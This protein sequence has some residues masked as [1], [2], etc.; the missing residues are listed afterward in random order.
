[1]RYVIA[2]D[3]GTGGVKAS[4]VDEFGKIV[5]DSFI[6]YQTYF[7]GNNWQEQRPDDW[8]NA[9]VESTHKLL[10]SRNELEI[11][12]IVSLAISGHS[13][14]VVPIGKDGELLRDLTPIWSDQRADAEAQEF[15]E[16]VDYQQWYMTTGNGFPAPCYSVFKIM[17]YKNHERDMFERMDKV[18]GTKDYCNYMFTGVLATDPS[19]ASGSGVFNLKNWAYEPTFIQASGL[20][21]DIFPQII[22]S[23]GVV[24]CITPEAAKLT[25]L[26][27][28]VKVICGGVDNSCMALGAKG[29]AD[30]R[31]YT[32]LGSSAWIALVANKPILDFKYKPY[33][34]AHLIEGMY[35]SATCIFSAGS[36]FQWVRNQLCKDLME[37]EK[38]GGE[39]CYE[40]M[41]R[42]AESSPVGANGVLFNPS[43]A[44]G[45]SIEPSPDISGGFV[46]LRLQH[47]REDIIRASM[48][49]VALNL[50]KALDIFRLYYPDIKKMLI[51]GGGA[52]SAV[53]MQIFANVYHT[54]IEKTNIDQQ[55]ATLGAA[56]LALKGVG[57][58]SDYSCMDS[59]HFTE[60]EYVPNEASLQYASQIY[61]RFEK[62]CNLLA[63]L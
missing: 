54:E 40:A 24:G 11:N 60:A 47:T 7:S 51:V 8:W 20:S 23:D 52:K 10:A 14:G 2:Y 59:I 29:N 45:S 44:G 42:L 1:M 36:S 25:G 55:A 32:S 43:L 16:K 58:W 37:A 19:Y 38:S 22:P 56:A 30:G 31:V 39:N 15:F 4:L 35:A 5:Q 12:S 9:V 18:I 27:E 21:P 50:K 46:G 33:V 6:P 57:V 3:L 13:L 53:W 34:F 48:E 62:L 61:P 41:N 26:P 49:G 17:W 28:G 63:D